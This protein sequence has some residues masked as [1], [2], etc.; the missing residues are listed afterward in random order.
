[1]NEHGLSL[2]IVGE[3]IHGMKESSAWAGNEFGRC[4]V[5]FHTSALGQGWKRF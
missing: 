3:L 5:R 2:R 4:W 1:M